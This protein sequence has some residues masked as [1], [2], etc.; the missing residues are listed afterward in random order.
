MAYRH[1]VVVPDVYISNPKLSQV[2][3]YH[4]GS[5]RVS[6]NRDESERAPR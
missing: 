3:L 5:I 2:G 4:R 1:L 6:T